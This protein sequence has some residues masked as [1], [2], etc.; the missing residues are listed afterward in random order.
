MG[1]WERIQTRAQRRSKA[2]EAAM[3]AKAG[4]TGFVHSEEEKPHHHIPAFKEATKKWRL[5]F[6]M[7]KAKVMG[8][9]NSGRFRLETR[10]KLFAMR[11]L[12]LWN[13]L[14]KEIHCTLLRC[15]WTWLWVI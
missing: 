12:S 15:S 4:K 5:P 8:T 10:G 3:R 13:N 6:Y 9:D 1:R 14:P 11:T 2:W 7:E